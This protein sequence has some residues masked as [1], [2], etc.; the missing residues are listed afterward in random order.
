MFLSSVRVPQLQRMLTIFKQVAR[1]DG[2]TI[3]TADIKALHER[4]GEPVTDAEA[5]DAIECMGAKDGRAHFKDFLNWWTQL[6]VPDGAKRGERYRA[7]FKFLKA[8]IAN[9]KVGAITCEGEG[10][11]PSLEYRVRFFA[12]DEHGIKTQIS[13]WHS[14]PLRNDDG[15]FNFICEIPKW[16]RKKMEIATGEPYNPIKQ[17]TKNGELRN[18]K[19]GDMLFNCEWAAAQP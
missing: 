19:W 5:E 3:G 4:L 7:R 17:D 1:G 6:H 12:T 2:D 14:V 18:Y 11:F 8:R 9:P 16:T 13:P 15:T 10:R